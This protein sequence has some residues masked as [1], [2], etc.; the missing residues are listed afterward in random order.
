MF[1]H[2]INEE[3]SLRLLQ[4]RHASELFTL[5][6]A[7]RS[8][9]R[10]WLPWLDGVRTAADTEAF[11]L[12]SLRTFAE[13]GTFVCGIWHAQS[14]CGVVGY[15]HIDWNSGTAQVGYWL[16][17]RYTGKG[18]ATESCGALLAHA[19][20]EYTMKRV[21]IAV[22]TENHRS[23]AVAE[24]LGCRKEGILHEAE[25]LYDHF[26]DHTL[27]VLYHSDYIRRQT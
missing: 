11:I 1:A 9:L 2:S 8:H 6:N 20:D 7:N 4:Q 23:Q 21:I 5:T 17:E 18:I 27:N 19:F 13:T 16:A 3:V 10:Q 22:A 25:W 15:N 12:N 26:V 24:R 14:L